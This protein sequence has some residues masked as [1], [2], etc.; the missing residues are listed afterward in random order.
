MISVS[1]FFSVHVL[2]FYGHLADKLRDMRADVLAF[3]FE[4]NAS[5]GCEELIKATQ[6]SDA[7]SR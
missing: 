7:S 4:D 5:P 6:V 3:Y 2:K 1:C